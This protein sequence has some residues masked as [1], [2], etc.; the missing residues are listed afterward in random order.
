MK[1][2][3]DIDLQ[4]TEIAFSSK[5]DNQLKKSY[6]LLSLMSQ[7][8]LV[9]IGSKLGLAAFKLRLPFVEGIVKNTVFEQFCGG[10]TLLDCQNNIDKLKSQNTFTILDYGAEGKSTEEDFNKTMNETIKALHFASKSDAIPIVSTKITGLC[11]FSLLEKTNQGVNNLTAEDSK[12]FNNLMKR[13]DSICHNA[14]QLGI[15]IFIDAEETWIQNSID[16][17]CDT[18]MERYNKSKAIVYNTFQMYRKD[19]LDFLKKSHA[20][21]LEKQYILG[22]KLV[23]GA[24]MEKER[25][26]AQDMGYPSPINE[27]KDATDQMYNA[28]ITYCIE[29]YTSIASCAATHNE[30]SSLLQVELIGKTGEKIKHPHFLFSQL[31]GMSDNV[32]FNIATAGYNSS[33]YVPYGPIRDVIPYLIRRAEEN[34]AVKGEMSRELSLVKKE[35]KRRASEN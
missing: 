22:A 32:T 21:A 13:I 24:Y 5:T 3:S 20:R 33:K 16:S 6:Q 25:K 7:P 10:T 8:I 11:A 1:S 34:T 19:R 31:F 23:R 4:N 18:M 29:N 15:G 12:E 27:T 14:E 26:R 17:I 28:G 2:H 35:M 9:D 30:I